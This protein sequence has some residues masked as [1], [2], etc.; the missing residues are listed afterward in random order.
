MF[1]CFTMRTFRFIENQQAYEVLNKLSTHIDMK[2]LS[3]SLLLAPFIV[4]LS[5]SNPSPSTSLTFATPP[6]IQTKQLLDVTL[7]SIIEDLHKLNY[8]KDINLL[9]KDYLA[10]RKHFKR[11]EF[12]VAYLDPQLYE[13]S[14]NESPLLKPEPKVANKETHFPKGFQVI[15]EMLFAS[16]VDKAALKKLIRHLTQ[17]IESFRLTHQS[18]P[19]YDA[20]IIHAIKEQLIRS[21][22][23]GITGFDSPGS[24]HA[25]EDFKASNDGMIDVLFFHREHFSS[26]LIDQAIELFNSINYQNFDDFDRYQYLIQQLVP[27]LETLEKI[28]QA[29]YIESKEELY[30]YPLAINS[31]FTNPFQQD[32]L[33]PNYFLKLPAQELSPERIALGKALFN[34]P[35][36]SHNLQTSCASCHNEQHAFTDLVPKSINHSQQDTTSRNAPSLNYSVFA[37][38]YFHDLRAHDLSN[39]FDHVIHN[40]KEFN[41]SYTEIIQKLQE[42]TTYTEQFQHAYSIHKKPIN[43]TTIN[44]ALKSYLASLPSFDAP[45]DRYV[46]TKQQDIPEEIRQGFNLFMGKAQCATCHFPPTFSGLVPPHFK[47]TES[48][49]L[50]VLVDDNFEQPVLDS[51]QG[52]YAN[53]V[54]KDRFDFFKHSFKTVSIRNAELTAP[55]MH[56]GSLQTL[57]KVIDFYNEGGGAGL[58]LDLPNQTLPADKLDLNEKEKQALIAFIKSLTDEQY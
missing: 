41:S 3:Y 7:L 30:P 24:S 23:L 40:E 33:Q 52:R 31:T 48:E 47:D 29:H 51:D 12:L 46:Q 9:Q 2:Y 50:G 55:Y 22:T 17:A 1:L 4:L 56:N 18:T 20:I 34:D 58:G 57:E 37:S 26:E 28:R 42:K 44:H 25:M 53:H 10:V 43:S 16:S 19:L 36:L 39:Q 13:K 27:L 21:F 11:I 45:F 8:E 6:S 5:I 49:V 54:V 35:I 15:D 14:I 32:F 38:A